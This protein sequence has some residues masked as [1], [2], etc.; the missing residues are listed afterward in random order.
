[1]LAH[2]P[3]DPHTFQA[4]VEEIDV[5]LVCG[6]AGVA[7]SNS[8]KLSLPSGERISAWEPIDIDIR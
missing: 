8:V 7:Q 5:A 4:L 3:A 6:A 1:M 2:H